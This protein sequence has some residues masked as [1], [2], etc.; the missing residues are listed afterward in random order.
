MKLSK[1]AVEVHQATQKLRKRMVAVLRALST[2]QRLTKHQ[3]LLM[4]LSC[5]VDATADTPKLPV[6]PNGFAVNDVDVQRSGIKA[7]RTICEFRMVA[8][9]LMYYRL[10]H[11]TG[12]AQ[13]S[14][15]CQRYIEWLEAY[16]KDSEHYGVVQDGDCKPIYLH[17]F[18]GRE[19]P[20]MPSWVGEET[21]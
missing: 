21:V 14:R 13:D 7:F 8:M 5:A 9:M 19:T 11:A 1:E 4:D 12:D 20:K 18:K 2:L 16:V 3:Q 17:K 6:D 10:Y 15:S